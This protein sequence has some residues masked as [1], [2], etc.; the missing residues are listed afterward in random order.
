MSSLEDFDDHTDDFD[1]GV[2]DLNS[3]IK[4][5]NKLKD[6]DT[7]KIESLRTSMLAIKDA[8]SIDLS[9][10]ASV[11][12]NLEKFADTVGKGVIKVDIAAKTIFS[13][14]LEGLTTTINESSN[15]E[16]AELKKINKEQTQE[17][18]KEMQELRR[19]TMLLAEQLDPSR[20]KTV[21]N[22]DGFRVGKAL[23][24]RY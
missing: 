6:I 12:Q 17:H 15:R 19:Q 18:R 8:T 21:I 1:D 4:K 2:S 3:G 10:A 20:R 11:L 13:E 24:S 5:F 16:L 14:E 22:M 23:T 9:N 7:T